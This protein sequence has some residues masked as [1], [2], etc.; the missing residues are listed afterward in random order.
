MNLGFVTSPSHRL[1]QILSS[2]N[3]KEKPVYIL[4][5]NGDPSGIKKTL[6]RI[7][8]VYICINLVSGKMF[9]CCFEW[10]V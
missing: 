10:N 1:S 5:S 8:G 2:Y 3:L 6:N 7:A 9:V 4:E